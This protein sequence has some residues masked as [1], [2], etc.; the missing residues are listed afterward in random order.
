MIM[1]EMSLAVKHHIFFV[2]KLKMCK[3]GGMS[4]NLFSFVPEN[5]IF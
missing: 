4:K 3:K 5:K 1:T 2:Y